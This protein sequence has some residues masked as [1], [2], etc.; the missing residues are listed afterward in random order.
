M[1]NGANSHPPPF[2]VPLLASSFPQ[3]VWLQAAYEGVTPEKQEDCE[4]DVQIDFGSTLY[5]DYIAI[6]LA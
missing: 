6:H 3:G 4:E 2:V 1:W 5:C